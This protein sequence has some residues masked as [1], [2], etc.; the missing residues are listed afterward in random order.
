MCLIAGA[1][2]MGEY[3]ECEYCCDFS[4]VCKDAK[5]H[6]HIN[7]HANVAVINWVQ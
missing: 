6:L 5:V 1:I 7:L 3:L 4:L 2:L